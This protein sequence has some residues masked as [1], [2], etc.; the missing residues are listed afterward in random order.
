MRRKTLLFVAALALALLFVPGN[1]QIVSASADNPAPE[2]PAYTYVDDVT[3]SL[4]ISKGTAA[5]KVVVRDRNGDTTR[6]TCTMTLQK[7]SGGSWINVKSWTKTTASNTLTISGTKSVNKGRYRVKAVV[8]AYKGGKSES[9]TRY[10]G[11]V[12]Y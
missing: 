12:T 8:K 5:A 1:V 11:T 10:S 4:S 3:P 2:M 7:Y 9:I 6:I